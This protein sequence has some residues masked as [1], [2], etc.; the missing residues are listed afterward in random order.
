MTLWPAASCELREDSTQSR[1]TGPRRLPSVWMIIGEGE[2]D[3]D[4]HF[5]PSVRLP[6]HLPRYRQKVQTRRLKRIVEGEDEVA[7]VVAMFEGGVFGA[8]DREMPLK[9]IVLLTTSH[10]SLH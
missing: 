10:H 9:Q 7:V 2:A 3:L 5:K 6:C 4:L 8:F 1:S